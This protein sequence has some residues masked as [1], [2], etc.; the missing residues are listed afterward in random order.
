MQVTLDTQVSHMSFWGHSTTRYLKAEWN[1]VGYIGKIWNSRVL[2]NYRIGTF[3]LIR[4]KCHLG[5]CLKMSCTSKMTCHKSEKDCNLWLGDTSNS[6]M[7]YISPCIVLKVRS[8]WDHSA[9]KRLAVGQKGLPVGL[10]NTRQH[11]YQFRSY[12]VQVTWVLSY[13]LTFLGPRF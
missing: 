4:F 2:I 9:W 5:V 12:L 3:G 8:F 11:I 6:H 7:G 10:R 1:S 13:V